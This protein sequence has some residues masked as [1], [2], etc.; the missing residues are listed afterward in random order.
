MKEPAGSQR[1]ART[2]QVLVAADPTGTPPP[3]GTPPL[4]PTRRNRKSP[5]QPRPAQGDTQPKAAPKQPAPGPHKQPQGR[6]L[7]L[8]YGAGTVALLMLLGIAASD[9]RLRG[10]KQ[11]VSVGL[12]GP[13]FA[14]P[15][16]LPCS[17][18]SGW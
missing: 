18:R 13:A 2:I 9:V 15:A 8:L 5:Y 7:S 1:T 14:G 17:V 12:A 10:A 11:V 6:S 4:T 16:L 3:S